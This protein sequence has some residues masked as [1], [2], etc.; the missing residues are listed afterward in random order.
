MR[1]GPCPGISALAGG[2]RGCGSGGAGPVLGARG[3][4]RTGQTTSLSGAS[5]ALQRDS[6]KQGGVGGCSGRAG[7]LRRPW[8]RLP[9]DPASEG[10]QSWDCG[11]GCQGLRFNFPVHKGGCVPSGS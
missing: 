5:A 8:G 3:Q 11:P 4:R 9:G 1:V 10:R 7:I 2:G 6:L